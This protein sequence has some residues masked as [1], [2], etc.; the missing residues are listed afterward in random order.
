[1]GGVL[2][3]GAEATPVLPLQQHGDDGRDTLVR[4]SSPPACERLV[5]LPLGSF[6]ATL[7]VAREF[8]MGATAVVTV[9]TTTIFGVPP[10]VERPALWWALNHCYPFPLL[11]HSSQRE[12]SAKTDVIAT[13]M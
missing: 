7:S 2:I 11:A 3:A 1:L 6:K 10:G 12:W 8:I 13:R 4:V 9:R 5:R